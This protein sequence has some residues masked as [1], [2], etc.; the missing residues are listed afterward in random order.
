M[1]VSEE[2]MIYLFGGILDGLLGLDLMK[3]IDMINEVDFDWE[4]LI[5][6]DLGSVVLSLELVFDMLEED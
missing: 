4:F 5:F 2:I 6:V 1:N 3:I